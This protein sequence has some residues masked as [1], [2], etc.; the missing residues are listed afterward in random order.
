[1]ASHDARSVLA[2]SHVAPFLLAALKSILI[3]EVRHPIRSCWLR[4]D[5]F[6]FSSQTSRCSTSW[7][8]R[9]TSRAAC[10]RRGK[11]FRTARGRRGGGRSS[12][13][14]AGRS[15]RTRR[16]WGGTCGR[17]S[18]P[19]PVRTYEA[20]ADMA[21]ELLPRYLEMSKQYGQ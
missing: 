21:W 15:L 11:T 5:L 12:A 16:R 9:R 10:L 8:A 2:A 20:C 6:R 18:E 14:C 7:S 19:N 4:H 13:S 3:G 17:T 1:M